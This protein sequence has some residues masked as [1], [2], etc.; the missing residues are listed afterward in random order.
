MHILVGPFW[1]GGR[2]PIAMSVLFI[3]SSAAPE[4]VRS[5]VVGTRCRVF[6]ISLPWR[7][8]ALYLANKVDPFILL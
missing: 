5:R 3:I 1:W 2:R 4:L 8:F 6:R 7:A